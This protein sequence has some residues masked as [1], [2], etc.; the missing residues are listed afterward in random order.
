MS[1]GERGIMPSADLPLPEVAAPFLNCQGASLEA[2]AAAVL[3]CKG[4]ERPWSNDGLSPDEAPPAATAAAS[5]ANVRLVASPPPP[6]AA[7]HGREE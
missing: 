1:G 2:A 3:S 6:A 5:A 7:A 4:M